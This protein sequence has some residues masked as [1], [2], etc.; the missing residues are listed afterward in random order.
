MAIIITICGAVFSGVIAT[1]VNILYSIHRDKRETEYRI[2]K[3]KRDYKMKLLSDILGYRGQITGGNSNGKN[4]EVA[5]N[6]VFLAFQDS[7]EVL[8][9]FK[10]FQECA[11]IPVPKAPQEE[12]TKERSNKVLDSLLTL[13]KSMCDNLQISYTFMNDNL[14]LNP[15]NLGQEK[16]P[17]IIQ[18]TNLGM[19]EALQ[20][21]AD[22]GD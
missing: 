20:K 16:P 14:F 17:F 8:S 5:M 6:Q 22:K 7:S 18:L 15:L 1:F 12:N 19:P 4:F 3:E 21:T 11:E 10:V 9:K 13:I 2:A